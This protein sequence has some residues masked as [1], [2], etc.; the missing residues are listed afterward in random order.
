MNTY[1]AE[2]GGRVTYLAVEGWGR[3]DG[4]LLPPYVQ[5]DRQL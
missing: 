5:K 4:A 3:A 1:L 2:K